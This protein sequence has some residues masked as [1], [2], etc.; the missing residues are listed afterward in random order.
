MKQNESKRFQSNWT[1]QNRDGGGAR[2]NGIVFYRSHSYEPNKTLKSM[3]LMTWLFEIPRV[4]LLI[5]KNPPKAT[6]DRSIVELHWSVLRTGA[7][8][9]SLLIFKKHF[10][11]LHIHNTH[12][13]A[14]TYT[15]RTHT[16]Y[17]LIVLVTVY[18]L[19]DLPLDSDLYVIMYFHTNICLFRF[20]FSLF[21][22]TQSLVVEKR[23]REKE[24]N[25]YDFWTARLSV[26]V[27]VWMCVCL[28]AAH[29]SN[30]SMY[31]SISFMGLI[32]HVSQR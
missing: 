2:P 10:Q 29:S 18:H 11:L 22:S 25:V 19:P 1:E 26:C 20:A 16:G 5:E 24:K 15:R 7:T 9:K 4:R 13:H 17:S 8:F 23:E 6:I 14:H 30:I 12:D 31:V 3:C 32:E 28:C 21:H 27:S